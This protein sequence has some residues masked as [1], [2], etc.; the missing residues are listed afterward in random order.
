MGY[1]VVGVDARDEPIELAKSLKLAPHLCLDAREGVESATKAI[2]ALN[3][4]KPFPGKEIHT[5]GFPN[6]SKL[7]HGTLGLDA[8]IVATDWIPS[9]QYGLDILTRHGT[10][11]VVRISSHLQQ[12]PLIIC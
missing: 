3:P 10:L 8:C 2:A 9:F 4:E 1:V 7:T 6:T 5:I 12:L 11:I